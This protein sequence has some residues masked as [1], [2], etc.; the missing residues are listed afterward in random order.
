[1]SEQPQT[2]DGAPSPG[3]R[4]GDPTGANPAAPTPPDP[5]PVA[6]AQAEPAPASPTQA[7]PVE[8]G[9][10]AGPAEPVELEWR[11]LHPL[12]PLLR[13]GLF[14]LVVA[15][16]VIANLRDRLFELFFAREFVDAMGPNEGDLIDFLI[17]EH[18]L[19][20]AF[21]AVL[22][23]IA[24]II[25][26]SWL[27]WRFSTFRITSE[28]VE[29][30]R[31]VLFRQHR[32]APLERIQSVNLQRSLL[33]RVLGL[34]QVDVQTAGQGG[35]VALQYLGHRDAKQ[36]REQILR[37]VGANRARIGAGA[38]NA[39]GAPGPS[40]ASN[41]VPGAAAGPG[42]D[43]AG[44]SRAPLAVDFSGVAYS[45][46]P[47]LID[48]RLRDLTDFDIDPSA[49]ETGMLI[50]VPLGRLLGSI[51]LSSET[52]TVVLIAIA[53][54]VSS[55]WLSPFVLASALPLALVLIGLLFNQF[56]KGFNFVLSR[57]ADGV[58]VGAGLTATTTETIPFG[59]VHAVEA[60]QPLGWRPFGWWKVRITT[61][62]HSVSQAGQN[63]L[64]NTV[65]PVG[66]L[67]DVLRVF[68]T[69][70]HNGEPGAE[71]RAAAL[72][73]ALVGPGD[74][75]LRAGPRAGVVLWFGARRAGLRVA[76]IVGEHSSLRIRRGW[77]TRSLVV[78]PILRAQSVQLS[79]PPVHR[80][81][82]LATLQAHTV[83]GPVR[84]QMRGIALDEAREAFD[85][86]AGTVVRVQG[87]E[88]ASRAGAAGS[89][90]PAGGAEA[91]AEADP[92]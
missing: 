22:V 33:A 28:A 85:V 43:S 6:P 16:I 78:M 61:A 29:S 39:A 8:P 56:N 41:A 69:L 44:G 36:V 67:D 11:R 7:E 68:E 18:L 73:Q 45:E 80:A 12:S 4:P 24:A 77:L 79:R 51:L 72:Q 52:M 90:E 48:E 92:G 15:G 60:M 53:I 40:A 87:A 31:G 23:A 5:G 82:G 83:L 58:R 62:G 55:I 35:K 47:G 30:R 76:D 1:M 70:L 21:V 32:R 49:R 26:F 91:S 13:G 75:F 38:A 81:L 10:P 27:S 50:K 89:A 57:A 65:L 37:A 25:G 9:E 84:M 88:A 3:D 63:K 46:T 64:Q 34:T 14:L 19:V 54:G 20:W 59:R 2:G 71:D 74:G 86:L 17:G 42:P 66:E